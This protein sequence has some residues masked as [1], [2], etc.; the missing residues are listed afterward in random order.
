MKT[1]YAV[2]FV[3]PREKGSQPFIADTFCAG[4]QL[5]AFVSRKEANKF[6]KACSFSTHP[7]VKATLR[8]QP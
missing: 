8:V 6:R 2:W 5:M 1:N 4:W 3:R 7:P